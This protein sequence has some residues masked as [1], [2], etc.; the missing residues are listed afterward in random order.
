M[1]S[2]GRSDSSRPENLVPARQWSCR[3]FDAAVIALLSSIVFASPSADHDFS[4]P[5]HPPQQPQHGGFRHRDASR[6]GREIGPRQMQEHGAAT[7]GNSRRAVVIDFDDEVVEV[8]LARQPVTSLIP[9]QTD[10]LV[11]TAVL[12]VLA[13]GIFL[14]DRPNRQIGPRSGMAV[15]AP[16]QL[17]R[18]IDASRSTAVALPFVGEDAAAAKC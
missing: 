6:R 11:I 18:M 8:I 15:G 10:W 7:A 16:P 13:P 5:S 2:R 3:I 12:R 1:R 17:Q 14:P 9:D 4:L